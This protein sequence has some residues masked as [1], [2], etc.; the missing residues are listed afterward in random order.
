MIPVWHLMKNQA[1]VALALVSIWYV[2][3]IMRAVQRSIIS[4]FSCI[5]CHYYGQTQLKHTI[6]GSSAMSSATKNPLPW[7]S[8]WTQTLA[9]WSWNSSTIICYE[10]AN[11]P[12]HDAHKHIINLSQFNKLKSTNNMLPKT[13]IRNTLL[14]LLT[15][16]SSPPDGWNKART[17]ISPSEISPN[18]VKDH[19][20]WYKQP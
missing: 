18:S 16:S 5:L 14:R 3:L 6:L 8:D 2:F 15:S 7:S 4:V 20:P 19:S 10:M 17:H 9:K 13:Y 1:T 11:N 12:P